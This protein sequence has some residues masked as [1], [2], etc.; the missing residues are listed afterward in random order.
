[1]WAAIC[2]RNVNESLLHTK[3]TEGNSYYVCQPCS[4][5]ARPLNSSAAFNAAIQ[6]VAVE[7]GVICVRTDVLEHAK[8]MRTTLRYL[9]MGLVFAAER[10]VV[11]VHIR[12]QHA[13]NIC[14]MGVIMQATPI[15]YW[16]DSALPVSLPPRKISA[17]A[18][19]VV[20]ELDEQSLIRRNPNQE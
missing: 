16:C 11:A 10:D 4:G 12:T 2:K 6:V 20:N 3:I 18:F 7:M 15:P 5:T 13:M 19:A 8:R 1:M 14:H 17:C 9:M